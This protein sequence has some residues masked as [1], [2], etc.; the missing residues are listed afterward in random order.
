[1][2]TGLQTPPVDKRAWELAE[3]ERSQYEAAHTPDSSLLTDES[4]IGRYLDPPCTTRNPLE[5]V[6]ALLGDIRGLT[7]LDYGC[8]SGE[9]CLPLV[10]R[11]ARVIAAD[12]SEALIHVA[13]RRLAVNG[14]AGEATFVVA[15]AHDLP[16]RRE[17]IDVV[18]GVSILHH[19]DLELSSR[20]LARVLKPGGR[21]IFQEPV[22][23][24][25]LLC[26]LRKL[27]PYHAQGIS[28]YE[29]PLTT[30]E[31][32]VFSSPFQTSKMRAF[33]LP[34][35]RLTY[36]VPRLRRYTRSAYRLD[37]ALIE[38]FPATAPFA[39]LRVFEVVK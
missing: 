21:G 7:V 23:D 10:R 17:S 30:A 32:R 15:S 26:V 36:V 35:V 39:A 3:I 18:V 28:P 11:G 20:E 1:M 8:G 14:L 29:R 2:N 37:G 33:C 16:L 12:I 19:L 34:F 24:S 9:N 25:R 5:Y 31:L 38:H 13:M 27:V 22:R 4:N 6:F